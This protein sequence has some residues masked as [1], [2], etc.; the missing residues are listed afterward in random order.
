MLFSSFYN[1]DATKIGIKVKLLCLDHQKLIAVLIIPILP[2]KNPGCAPAHA[3]SKSRDALVLRLRNLVDLY[4]EGC[5]LSEKLYF[6]V[7][8][9]FSVIAP[10]RFFHCGA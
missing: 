6:K 7:F 2:Y 3:V 10:P 1:Q 5:Y 4:Q 8:V 9:V